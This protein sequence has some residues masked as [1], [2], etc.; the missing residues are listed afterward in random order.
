MDISEFPIFCRYTGEISEFS[1]SVLQP[2]NYFEILILDY[3]PYIDLTLVRA[4]YLSF[5]IRLLVSP[6][7]MSQ[8]PESTSLNHKK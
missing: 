5:C 3:D 6:V 1:S 2:T 4:R 7:W 8:V